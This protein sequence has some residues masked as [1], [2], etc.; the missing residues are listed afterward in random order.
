MG[1]L[2]VGVAAS[3]SPLIEANAD[4]PACRQELRVVLIANRSDSKAL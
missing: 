4:V 3:L 2:K 1:A